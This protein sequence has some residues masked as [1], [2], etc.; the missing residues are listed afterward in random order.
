MRKTLDA[1]SGPRYIRAVSGAPC[2]QS[3][4]YGT[5]DPRT[6]AVTDATTLIGRLSFFGRVVLRV[7]GSR[8]DLPGLWARVRVHRGGAGVL[9]P[10]WIHGSTQALFVVPTPSARPSGI[11]TRCDG[12][13]SG[14]STDRQ[15]LWRERGLFQRRAAPAPD[16]RSAVRE[17]RPDRAVAVP[18]DRYR[19]VY[20]S[21]CFQT[22]PLIGS[23]ASRA[24]PSRSRGRVQAR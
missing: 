22:A 20:C 21:D 15:R 24:A 18:A 1:R 17:L 12:Y 3:A 23:G 16:V 11:P 9:R 5:V 2:S 14:G 19:P 6:V 8:H 10:T 7:Y 4:R 13:S